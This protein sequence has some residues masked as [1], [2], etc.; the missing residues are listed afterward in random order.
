[1]KLPNQLFLYRLG[2]LYL[3]IPKFI[4]DILDLGVKAN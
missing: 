4:L 2:R 3:D 1:M